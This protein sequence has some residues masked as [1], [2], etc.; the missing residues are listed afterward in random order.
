[1]S[2]SIILAVQAR[3]AGTR[4]P[5]KVMLPIGYKPMLL[6]VMQRMVRM[7][8]MDYVETGLCRTDA[9]EDWLVQAWAEQFHFRRVAIGKP[10]D[11]WPQFWDV[12]RDYDYCMRVCGDQ[13]L[14]SIELARLLLLEVRMHPGADYYG[15]VTPNGWPASQTRL[16]LTTE[17]F[18]RGAMHSRNQLNP[19][20]REHVTTEFYRHPERY[21]VRM[22]KLPEAPLVERCCCTVDNLDDARAVDMIVKDC[23]PHE[24]E[25]IDRG[26]IVRRCREAEK[27]DLATINQTVR[28]EY[29]G[30][31]YKVEALKWEHILS[32]RSDK[33]ITEVSSSQPSSSG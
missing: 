24:P 32:L 12:S 10:L 29:D 1:M 9:K 11:M 21:N 31:T 25:R 20:S 6:H 18:R 22:L 23:N 33:T 8:I 14:F 30:P 5:G 15:W 26:H 2:V 17:V 4:Q 28:K 3:M 16:G 27:K 7:Q 13:P 19:E